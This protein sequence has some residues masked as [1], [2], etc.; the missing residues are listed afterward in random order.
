MSSHVAAGHLSK[1]SC[2]SLA[3]FTLSSSLY[4]L[5]VLAKSLRSVGEAGHG[6]PLGSLHKTLHGMDGDQKV[7]V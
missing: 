5:H 1:Y 3:L 7:W 2:G 6:N 4:L